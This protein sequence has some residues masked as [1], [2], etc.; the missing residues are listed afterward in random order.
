MECQ[1]EDNGTPSFFHSVPLHLRQQG[2][3]IMT[4][5]IKSFYADDNGAT[6]IEYALIASLIALAMI[7]GV[8]A[9]GTNLNTKFSNV[10]TKLT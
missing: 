10:S 3:S 5:L 7:A 2:Q 6:A 8:T 1:L 9:V 4:N